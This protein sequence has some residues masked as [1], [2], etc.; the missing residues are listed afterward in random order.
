MLCYLLGLSKTDLTKEENQKRLLKKGAIASQ[1]KPPIKSLPFMIFKNLEDKNK[2]IGYLEKNI[3]DFFREKS[4]KPTMKL[5]DDKLKEEEP[6]A[7]WAY[8][9]YFDKYQKA[10]E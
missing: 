2:F 1:E 8:D 7:Y 5:G 6:F 9:L 3:D 10:K 4:I